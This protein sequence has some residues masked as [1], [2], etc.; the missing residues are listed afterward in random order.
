MSAILYGNLSI[1]IAGDRGARIERIA[2]RPAA[3]QLL[4][5]RDPEPLPKP[6]IL[7]REQELADA[8]AAIRAGRAIGFHAACGY[9]KTILLRHIAATSSRQHG[10]PQCI[11][12]RADQDRF[13]DLLQ[14][15]VTT[16]FRSDR[17]VKPTPDECA[18]LLGQVS[19]IVAIDDVTAG[20]DQVGR[21]LE[22]LRGCS[23]VI[24][25]TRPVLGQ[26]GSSQDL[27]GLPA[28]TALAVLA[29]HLGRPLTS[30]EVPDARRLAAA[31]DGQP[32]HLI[33]A[34]AL[35]R[36]DGHSIGSLAR[37]AEHDP[38][39]L[40]R[41]SI[42]ALA[43]YER[44]TLAALALAAGALLP[45]TVVAVLGQ[46][47]YLGEGLESLHRRGLAQQHHD[48]FGLPVCQ[49]RSY[50]L[51]LL[52]DIHLAASAREL[53]GWLMA[54]DPSAVESQAAAE[55][56]LSLTEYA[57]E[58]GEWASVAQLARA[59]EAVLFTAGRWEAWHHA[60]SHGLNAAR[61]TGDHEADAYFSHQLGSFAFAQDHLDDAASLLRHALA[62]REQIGDRDGAD[63]SRHNL[64]LLAPPPAAQLPRPGRRAG[65][66]RALA[67]GFGALALAIATIAVASA[68][69]GGPGHQVTE[70]GS[71]ASAGTTASPTQGPSS[72]ASPGQGATG[73]AGTNSGS[74]PA[75]GTSS[76][77]SS[78]SGSGS[79]TATTPVSPVTVPDVTGQTESAAE[80][81]LKNAGL[82]ASPS[83]TTTCGSTPGGDVVRQNPGGGTS[84]QPGSVVAIVVC[85]ATATPVTVPNVVGST[86][87]NAEAALKS[88]GLAASPD[89]TT[90]TSTGP[91]DVASQDP[92]GGT[93][94]QPGATVSLTCATPV[95]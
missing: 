89:P 34:A 84:A 91:L 47:S 66:A 33:Q 16:L 6:P 61:A 22:I 28:D 62:L 21:L 35:V 38:D 43:D 81:A 71:S 48:R 20:P 68:L 5:P 32:L 57:A 74:G 24:T 41:L 18:S 88:A 82:G 76:S 83:D 90:C 56:A 72:G 63:L 85:S 7:G 73:G 65:V 26:L 15:V 94:A 37:Q 86:L 39:V 95:A 78:G 45:V 64:R 30:Q 2:R 77:P 4:S 29:D 93:T 42:S 46:L 44:R 27:A 25:S 51:M 3:A 49:A 1:E 55:A 67:G 14:Q 31:V 23:V 58:R 11:Y 52:A 87:A 9:G 92:A 53:A 70:T 50:R 40:D 54:A 59:A 69:R 60:L 19:A 75:Q 13:W 12:V 80:T 8:L 36:E 17:P 79:G 10:A